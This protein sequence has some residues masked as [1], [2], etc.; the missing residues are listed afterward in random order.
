MSLKKEYEAILQ[1]AD[2][3]FASLST[4]QRSVAAVRAARARHS[5][6]MSIVAIDATA[7]HWLVG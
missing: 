6:L 5:S 7:T 1:H 3:I 4:A 2:D